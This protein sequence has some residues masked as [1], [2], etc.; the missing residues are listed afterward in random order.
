MATAAGRLQF[1]ELKKKGVW[2]HFWA[3]LFVK[4]GI[5][6]YLIEIFAAVNVLNPIIFPKG[7]K[8]LALT[9]ASHVSQLW[10]RGQNPD[11]FPAVKVQRGA[12]IAVFEIFL[13]S[14]HCWMEGEKNITQQIALDLTEAGDEAMFGDRPRSGWLWF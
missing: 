7:I 12:E 1:T 11:V 8:H 9:D 2:S 6:L 14:I 3:L 13:P 5:K 4:V 10:S